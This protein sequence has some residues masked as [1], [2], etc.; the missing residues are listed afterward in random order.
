M[1]N[2]VPVT[3]KTLTEL[4]TNHLAQALHEVNC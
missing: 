4:S 3:E 2:D 1:Q